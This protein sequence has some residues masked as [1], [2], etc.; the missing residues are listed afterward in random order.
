MSSI[1]KNERTDQT[2]LLFYL[3]KIDSTKPLMRDFAKS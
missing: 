3:A 1:E 2:F